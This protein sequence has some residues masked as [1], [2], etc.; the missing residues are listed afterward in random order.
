MAVL[1]AVAHAAAATVEAARLCIVPVPLRDPDNPI[2]RRALRH[3][4]IATVFPGSPWP[5]FDEFG[6][7]GTWVLNRRGQ[8]EL[9]DEFPRN[10]LADRFVVE[11]S[12][13]VIGVSSYGKQIYVQDAADGRFVGLDGADQKAIGRVAWAS[14][15]TGR[16][17]TLVATSK[18]VFTLEGQGPAP[19]LKPLEIADAASIKNVGRIY[20]LPAHR[21]AALGTYDGRVF[22]L[23][24]DNQL[25]AVPG[26]QMTAPDWFLSIE[27]V[28]HPERLLVQGSRQT[29]TVPLRRDG[30]ASVPGQAREISSL[31]H[32]GS[33]RLQYYSAVR[34]YLVYGTPNRWFGPG[35]A[36]LRLDDDLVA[37]EGSR[38]L[39]DHPFVRDVPSRGIVVVQT[40]G[41]LYE[42]DGNNPLRPI[43]GSTEAEIGRYPRVH[44]LTGQDKVIV[45]TISGLY[46]LTAEGNLVRLPLAPELE[47]A[48]FRE[49][50][51]LPASH[52]AVVF[53]D[54]G[55]FEL[56]P[57]GALTRVR[58]D[59]RVD[60]G[61]TGPNLIA[62]IP[63]R[64][65]LFVSTYHSGQFMILDKDRAG[66]E[67]CAAAR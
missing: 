53:T 39:P 14:W 50:A 55:I 32:D 12:G 63:V 61:T 47:G 10:G 18:G 38:G 44:D 48:R 43:P 7:P 57:A 28:D 40:F 33:G 6:P 46:E 41:R 60:P 22:L 67:A 29:W 51:E 56:D 66:R 25:R 64:E 58:G 13:R 49:L 17:A 15:V 4:S 5:V 26:L 54:R 27:Q 52:L 42:Y 65:T 1:L 23:N 24:A 30:D 31:V 8:L 19:T 3:A 45:N 16:R 34:Q 62:R 35:P 20:D 21:A 37:V 2:A 9:P 59:S 11:P 36:L